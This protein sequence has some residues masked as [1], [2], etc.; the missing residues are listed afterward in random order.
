MI[1]KR[2]NI[3]RTLRRRGYDFVPLDFELCESQIN[4]FENRIGHR[5]YKG[6]FG[7]CHRTVEIKGG[8]NYADGFS[9]FKREKVPPHTEFDVYGI[10]H[11]STPT[12]FHMTRMHHP[13][14]GAELSEIKDYPYPSVPGDALKIITSEVEKLHK[15]DL[16]AYAF[17]QM[18]I[19][20][21]AWYL[22]SMEEIM[23]D[24]MMEDE[25][26]TVLLDSITSYACSKYTE[27]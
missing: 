18:T 12:S 27:K 24:M 10:G 19:W 22:R 14:K 7:Q 16:A 11:S 1:S 3:L 15:Q 9:L 26:A 23:I 21:P 8:E 2:E 20:E 25:K 13:L 4:A 5:D 17:S 6:W